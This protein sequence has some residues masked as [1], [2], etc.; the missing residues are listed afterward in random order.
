[1]KIRHL[2]AVFGYLLP[3]NLTADKLSRW[4]V[5]SHIV[6][7]RTWD[8]N[9]ISPKPRRIVITCIWSSEEPDQTK[10]REKCWLVHRMHQPPQ[11]LLYDHRNHSHRMSMRNNWFWHVSRIAQLAQHVCQRATITEFIQTHECGTV[12]IGWFND[13][14]E[15]HINESNGIH[16]QKRTLNNTIIQWH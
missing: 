2:I 5:R 1:M 9:R 11:I 8:S 3:F 7:I 12:G 16:S 6:A 10:K 14:D 4:I 15:I 13:D